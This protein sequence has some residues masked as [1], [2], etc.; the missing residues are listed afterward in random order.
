MGN[1]EADIE[2]PANANKNIGNW[3]SDTN[4]SNDNIFF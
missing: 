3:K 4:V 2:I 1:N